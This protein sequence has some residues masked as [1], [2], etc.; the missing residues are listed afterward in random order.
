MAPRVVPLAEWKP[1]KGW[2]REYLRLPK[3]EDGGAVF[4]SR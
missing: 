1:T 2:D 3:H 4:Y